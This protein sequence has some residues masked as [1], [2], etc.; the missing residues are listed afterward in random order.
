M[1]P[2]DELNIPNNSMAID[3]REF[4]E[5]NLRDLSSKYISMLGEKTSPFDLVVLTMA[6]RKGTDTAYSL[7]QEQINS[8]G[9]STWFSTFYEHIDMDRSSKILEYLSMGPVPKFIMEGLQS[10][11]SVKNASQLVNN[12]EPLRSRYHLKAMMSLIQT[13]KDLKYATDLSTSG[14]LAEI[15]KC[16]I[17]IELKNM[18]F[19]NASAVTTAALS[20]FPL[21]RWYMHNS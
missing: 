3:E 10:I 17:G 14:Q 2:F 7:R 15:M 19:M 16:V 20:I 9:T 4:D 6:I 12:N 21:V 13:P 18:N 5:L 8:I 1:V 11:P